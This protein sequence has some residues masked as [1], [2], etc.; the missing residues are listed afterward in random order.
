MKR[1]KKTE[2]LCNRFVIGFCAGIVFV[3]TIIFILLSSSFSIVR[4]PSFFKDMGYSVEHVKL[5]DIIY[6]IETMKKTDYIHTQEIIPLINAYIKG[7][8]NDL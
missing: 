1:K 4:T 3:S 6:I 8:V 5:D 2:S 7:D